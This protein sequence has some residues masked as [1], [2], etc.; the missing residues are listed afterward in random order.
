VNLLRFLFLLLVKGLAQ[1]FYCFEVSWVGEKGDR[2]FKD[3]RIG[4]LLNHTSLFEPVYIGTLPVSLLWVMAKKAVFPGADITMNRPWVGTLIRGLAPKVMT[5]TR[6]RDS[7]WENFL[8]EVT[9]DSLVFIAPEGRMKRRNG[10][11]KAGKPMTVKSGIADVLQKLKTGKMILAYSGGLHHVQAPGEGFPKLFRKLK[12]R[13]EIVD[14]ASFLKSYSSPQE[15][16][17]EL[18]KRRDKYTP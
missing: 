14:I 17:S 18:E 6:K 11:D 5:V 16:V 13:Y 1:F 7:S 9:E 8:D 12:I 15:I 2:P 3:T 10:L 4:V